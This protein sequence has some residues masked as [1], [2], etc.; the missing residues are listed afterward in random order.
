M[1]AATMPRDIR[2]SL[3][4]SLTTT[5]AHRLWMRRSGCQTSRGHM[6]I[7]EEQR[8]K[9]YYTIKMRFHPEIGEMLDSRSGGG[10]NR[11]AYVAKLIANDFA[12]TNPN[13]P[14]PAKVTHPKPTE[15]LRI[16]KKKRARP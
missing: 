8:E 15:V 12:K 6:P 2:L 9:M 14:P 10:T 16:P 4:D 1:A 3:P 13:H 5:T 7:T 11:T